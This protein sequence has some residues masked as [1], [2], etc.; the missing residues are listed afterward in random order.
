M[1]TEHEQGTYTRIHRH[2]HNGYY[3]GD[4]SGH[5]FPTE[6]QLQ[7]LFRTRVSAAVG[8]GW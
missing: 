5:Q 6:E 1:N 2:R 4:F 3:A 7:V 8:V